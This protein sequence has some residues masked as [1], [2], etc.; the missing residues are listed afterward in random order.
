LYSESADYFDRNEN[1]DDHFSQ[2]SLLLQVMTEDARKNLI[3]NIVSSMS[4]ITGEKSDEIT[5]RQLCHFY[6]A[7]YKFGSDVA[8]ELMSFHEEIIKGW[9]SRILQV[10]MR[11]KDDYPELSK[12]IEEMKVTIPNDSHPQITI[13]NLKTYYES[14]TT[15]LDNYIYEHATK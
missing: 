15:V 1:D 3:S 7:D 6:R 14:L 13:Q 10:T 2:P 9:N 11:M 5:K 8:N 4:E 12:Y